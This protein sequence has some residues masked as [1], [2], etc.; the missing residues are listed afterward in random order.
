MQ[1]AQLKGQGA[2]LEGQGAV[3]GA[4]SRVRGYIEEFLG[5]TGVETISSTS[6]LAFNRKGRDEILVHPPGN[7]EGRRPQWSQAKGLCPE[8]S[9]AGQTRQHG[10][11]QVLGQ[12]QALW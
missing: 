12:E 5:R 11:L 3:G 10:S 4:R 8:G 1:G 6:S 2:Q 9:L 7:G